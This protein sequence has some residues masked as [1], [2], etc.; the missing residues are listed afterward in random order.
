MALRGQ[1]ILV[2]F[3]DYTCV[4]CQH[5][6]PYVKEWYKRYGKYGLVVVGV[7]TPK[8]PFGK[9]PETVQKAINRFGIEYP[10][11]MD[12]EYLIST[13]Y[14]HR[15]WPAMYLIDRY[16]YIRYESAGEGDYATTE[17]M[18]Q[19]LLY[20]AGVGADLPLPM[21]PV[22]ETDK[23][24]AIY[25][26]V[27]PELFAGYSKGSIGNVEGYSPESVVR[28]VDPKMYLP[29]RFYAAGHWL[30]DKN[31]LRLN[32]QE[33]QEGH[34][35]LQYRAREVNA[36]MKPEGGKSCAVIATQDGGDLG[37]DNRGEDVSLTPDG[38]SCITVD[39][40]RMYNVVRNKEYGEHTLRLSS[41]SSGFAVYS[42]T[43]VSG[44]I[45]DLIS[46]N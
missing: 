36:V 9:N 14:R 21:E 7:H 20:G 31:C 1:V 28:Y 43:F 22:R 11:V 25:Y 37:T 17:H 27:P 15:L 4:G 26:P 2:E 8:F 39:E 41:Q 45:P 46:N 33:G 42:F 30:N 18:I 40:P 12:N 5:A 34:I 35:I 32:E 29:G 6:L 19:T 24:G 38:A 16:G 13:N 23:P 10:V 3:W 44:V